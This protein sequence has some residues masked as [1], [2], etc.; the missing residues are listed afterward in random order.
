MK[1]L[2]SNNSFSFFSETELKQ[3]KKVLDSNKVRNP[4]I[5]F[6]GF[7]KSGNTWGRFI[8]FNYW[9]ILN[10]GAKE[11]LTFETLNEIQ[12]HTLENQDTWQKE[13]TSGFP[14]FFHTHLSYNN[15][16]SLFD[17]IIYVK[18]NP[19]DTLISFYHFSKN[20]TNPFRFYPDWMKENLSR[21]VDLFVLDQL[22]NLIFHYF[23]TE[24]K[25]SFLINYEKAK[26][27]PF[28]IYNELISAVDG[29]CKS[30]ILKK[31]ISISSAKEIKKMSFES[32]QIKGMGNK[33]FT[34]VFVRDS[35]VNQYLKILK[36]KTIKTAMKAIK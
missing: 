32:G 20:R 15:A 9:N 36:Q 3:L 17:K 5:L 33:T 12:T 13:F 18:R 14:I 30:E 23:I 19:F 21:N 10:S 1:S 29:N 16:Y 22:P 7:P 4:T 8:L 31:A 24:K 25:A 27:N 11:T 2:N 35:S 26:E 28:E 34:G 6:S